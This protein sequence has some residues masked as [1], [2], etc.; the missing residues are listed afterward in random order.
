MNNRSI[1]QCFE[2]RNR[3]VSRWLFPRDGRPQIGGR[4]NELVKKR[5]SRLETFATVAVVVV[6]R[7][8]NEGEKQQEYFKTTLRRSVSQLSVSWKDH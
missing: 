5:K 2:P 1:E 4:T 6:Q 3:K 7:T 8:S